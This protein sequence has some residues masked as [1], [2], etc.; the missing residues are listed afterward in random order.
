MNSLEIL[1]QKH[2][3]RRIIIVLTGGLLLLP[4]FILVIVSGTTEIPLEKVCRA[5]FLDD[6]G[7]AGLV[8]WQIR[9]PR[10]FGAL[11]GGVG[12]ALAGTVLQVVLQNPLAAPTTLGISQGAAFGAALGITLL[13]IVPELQSSLHYIESRTFVNLLAFSFSLLTT[14]I[15]ILL[16]RL[17]RSG[18]ESIILAGIALSSLFMAGSTFL[19]YFADETRLA[20][21]VHWSFGDLTRAS[22]LD[23]RLMALVVLPTTIYFFLNRHNYNAL[24]AGNDVA[25]S[26]GVNVV[27]LRFLSM[28][29][30]ALTTSIPVPFFVRTTA[31]SYHWRPV[32]G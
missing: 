16:S 29:M 2:R 7:M 8:L 5:L 32:S 18:P 13:E 10:L 23:L 31:C 17:R 14:F 6:S 27:R 9:L 25:R 15:I 30:E 19:Q 24:L 28:F 21:I 12:L 3:R 1:Y 4:I 20:Q 26:L 11:L 22:W